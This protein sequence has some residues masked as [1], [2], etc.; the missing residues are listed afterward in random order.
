MEG[1][2]RESD[3]FSLSPQPFFPFTPGVAGHH[4]ALPISILNE[5]IFPTV[6]FYS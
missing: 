1:H 4:K 5:V 6:V 2:A 3:S